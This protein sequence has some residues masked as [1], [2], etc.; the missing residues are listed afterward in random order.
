MSVSLVLMLRRFP[1][2]FI[3]ER[4]VTPPSKRMPVFKYQDSQGV[5]SGNA[6]KFGY[7]RVYR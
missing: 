4:G 2:R 3:Y 1:R 5:I 6:I 7:R